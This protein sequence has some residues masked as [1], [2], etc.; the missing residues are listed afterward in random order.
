MAMRQST[1][2]ML[3]LGVRIATKSLRNHILCMQLFFAAPMSLLFV[4]RDYQ[5]GELTFSLMLSIVAASVFS[6]VVVALVGWYVILP[7]IN[8]R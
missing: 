3:R 5:F 6:G 8:V 7:S 1:R 4:L 2:R